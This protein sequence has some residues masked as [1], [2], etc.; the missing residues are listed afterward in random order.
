MSLARYRF[1]EEQ[2]ERASELKQLLLPLL[3]LEDPEEPWTSARLLALAERSELAPVVQAALERLIRYELPLL[4]EEE[5]LL[6]LKLDHESFREAMMQFEEVF[7]QARFA[8][9]G[10]PIG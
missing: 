3:S 6:A 7:W 1:I 5:R 4:E 8:E 9:E 2:L 10:S